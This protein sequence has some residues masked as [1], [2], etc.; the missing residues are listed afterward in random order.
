MGESERKF[1]K[2]RK[3]ERDRQTRVVRVINLIF[4]LSSE[5][6]E[7]SLCARVVTVSSR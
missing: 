1:M 5:E 7:G 4:N 6:G 2:K 3:D